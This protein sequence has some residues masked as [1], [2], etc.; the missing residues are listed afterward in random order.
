MRSGKRLLVLVLFLVS[1]VP[2]TRSLLHAARAGAVS[3]GV[4]E[5]NCL[6]CHKYPKMGAYTLERG[7]TYYVGEK[8][9]AQSVHA[10]VPCRGCHTDID[11]IPHRKDHRNVDCATACHMKD[12]FSNREFSHAPIRDTLMASIHAAKENEPPEKTR[13]KPDCKY[14]HL[15]PLIQY[16]RDYETQSSLKRCRDCHEARGVEKAFDHVLYRMGR[17]TSRDSTEI[18]DLCSS[19]H[20]DHS[21]M[22]VFDKSDAPAKGYKEYF[23]GKAVMRGWG[24][25][26]NCADCHTA[27]AV[28][29]KD[30]P[31]STVFLERRLA[32]C[33]ANPSCHPSANANFVQAAVHVAIEEE[34]NRAL[35][36]VNRGFR[37]L[38][39]G[40]MSF[41]ILHVALDLN[42]HF[43]NRLG[44]LRGRRR[45]RVRPAGAEDGDV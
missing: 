15:N 16:E 20:A 39:V 14:C 43:L 12:P 5:E 28:Y 38:T 31:R 30:D 3:R 1:S 36:W 35:I 7:R 4:D 9:Y 29:Q 32:T 8:S 23:H 6:M 2:L 18:V 26:A 41:L 40:T 17:R 27:H 42:R 21:L 45:R 25:P 34:E 19:C 44:A 33:G 10:K 37:L 24:K 11:Q 22:K 13:H